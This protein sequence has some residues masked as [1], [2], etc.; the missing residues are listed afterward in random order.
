M[1]K[2]IV[3][4]FVCTLLIAATVIPAAGILGAGN[5]KIRSTSPLMSINTYV[6]NISPYKIQSSPLTITATGPSDLDYIIL[7][8]RWSKDNASWYTYSMELWIGS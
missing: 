7:L 1:K 4:I 8:Y 6:D 2:K 5:I 3:G